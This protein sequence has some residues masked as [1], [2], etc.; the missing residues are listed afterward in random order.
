M[1]TWF[2]H[3]K[4]VVLEPTIADHED[5]LLEQLA[6]KP[7]IG[8]KAMCSAI[9]KAR[10]VTFKEAPI[11]AWLAAHKGALPMPIAEAASSS[12]GPSMALLRLSNLDEY[13]DFLQQH[14]SESPAITI[15]ELRDKLIQEHAVSCLEDTM[16][17]WLDRA[18]AAAPKR[19]IQR[20]S[21]DLPELED[22]EEEYGDYLRV[23][24]A[25][26]PS[27]GWRKLREAIKAEGSLCFA[28]DY[29]Q[30]A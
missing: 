18:R 14:L 19:A 8:Y 16:R 22:I 10:G 11:R 6:A 1:E 26:D 27:L 2:S 28:K 5:F 20:G 17:S 3:H 7:S 29:A 21:S 30:L 15:T 12:S 24:L 4:P 13:E 23:L 25:E 9:H